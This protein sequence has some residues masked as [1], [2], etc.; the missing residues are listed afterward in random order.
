VD[1]ETTATG[2]I[3]ILFPGIADRIDLGSK[4]RSWEGR[5]RTLLSRYLAIIY[6]IINTVFQE[7]E[8]TEIQWDPRRLGLQF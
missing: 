3:R 2:L 6:K 7:T 1:L 4:S 8:G 5:T